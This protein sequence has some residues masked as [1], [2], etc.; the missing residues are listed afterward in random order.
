MT[1]RDVE[2]TRRATN[3]LFNENRLKLGT[4]GTNV[5]YGCAATLAEGALETSWPNTRRINT[6]ADQAGFEA[7]VPVARWKG[8]GGPTNFNGSCFESYTWAAG[9]AAVTD[10][11]AVFSTSHVPTVHPIMAAKQAT[12]IDHISNGRFALNLVC[13]WFQ[14]ELEMFG[15]PLLEHDTRYEHAAEWLE[16]M[17]LL[18]TAEEE[19]DYE[20]RFFRIQRGFHQPKPIQRPFPAIMNAGGS[21]I[22]QRFAAR[23]VDI[24]FILVQQRDYEG[25]K[26]Q[27]DDF[28]R[29]AREE[30]GREIQIWTHCY[31]VCRPTQK[32]ATSYLQHYVREKGDWEAIDNLTR[33]MGL[34]NQCV[35]P[36]A[37]DAMKFHFVAGW[38][39]C[40][41]VGTPEQIVDALDTFARAGLDGTV[42]SWVNYEVELQQWIDK[43]MPMLEQAGLRKP[44]RRNALDLP[45]S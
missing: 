7:L 12:T 42:L 10:H 2:E 1:I 16:V 6:L 24:A 30:F 35:K 34:Q 19:F 29:V 4:F 26:A 20:G 33:I 17:K 13:G 36:E 28:R 11:A 8:F 15:A 21:A 32:E 27:V 5:S 38:G 39:G 9:L 31:V 43:V 14:P 25:I 40:P 3:P 44:H 45:R 23:Y 22:G 18:W 41:I 37:M